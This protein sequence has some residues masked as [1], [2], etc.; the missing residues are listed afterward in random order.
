MPQFRGIADRSVRATLVSY[1]QR[2]R[3]R[4]CPFSPRMFRYGRSGSTVRTSMRAFH[5]GHHFSLKF[6]FLVCAVFWGVAGAQSVGIQDPDRSV[7]PGNDFY[8][9]ANGNWLRT[10][11]MPAA[12]SSYDNRAM[13]A[14][15]TSQRV[16][17]I[18]Q[19][20]AVSHGAK[21]SIAQKVGDYY[22]SFLDIDRIEAQGTQS[23]AARAGCD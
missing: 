19:D 11:T 15:R 9:Y 18:V 23:C 1:L 17:E 2:R 22:A 14:E 21:G 5:R 10:V 3:V 7:K 13:L 4:K 6:L 12:Q 16:R 20:A 8:R